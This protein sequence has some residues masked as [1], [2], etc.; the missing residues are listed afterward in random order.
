MNKDGKR[1]VPS[2]DEMSMFLKN[3]I[4]YDGNFLN[5]IGHSDFR[6]P[7]NAPLLFETHGAD[8]VPIYARGPMAHL[9]RGV[10]EEN[11]IPHIMAVASCVSNYINCDEINKLA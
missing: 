5:V 9:Y 8:D 3:N 1:Y 7:S 2:I 10:M 11:V 4:E 6:M